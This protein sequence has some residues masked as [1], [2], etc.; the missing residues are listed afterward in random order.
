M[1]QWV[2]LHN[3]RFQYVGDQLATCERTIDRFKKFARLELSNRRWKYHLWRQKKCRRH[4]LTSI[5]W[6]FV[7]TS[8][9]AKLFRMSQFFKKTVCR[10]IGDKSSGCKQQVR[11]PE[12]WVSINAA[13]KLTLDTSCEY[14]FLTQFDFFLPNT[15][16]QDSSKCWL[17]NREN[18]SNCG[19]CIFRVCISKTVYRFCKVVRCAFVSH[20]CRNWYDSIA[21]YMTG[22]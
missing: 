10:G 1:L 8:C 22:T 15:S 11:K 5:F 4:L 6:A 3:C 20:D 18:P 19:V 16:L 14:R 12:F 2:A 21:N 13:Q 7:R 17:G 9:T